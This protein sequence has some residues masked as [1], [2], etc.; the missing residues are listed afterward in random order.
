MN[1]LRLKELGIKNLLSHKDTNIVFEDVDNFILIHGRD[2]DKMTYA[3]AGKSGIENAITF[4]LFGKVFRG[5][6]SGSINNE[7]LISNWAKETKEPLEINL[8]MESDSGTIESKRQLVYGVPTGTN[9][10][11]LVNGSSPREFIT[12]QAPAKYLTE[13]ILQMDYKTFSKMHSFRTGNQVQF[14]SLRGM[15]Q[16]DIL[17]K[18]VSKVNFSDMSKLISEDMVIV[19]TKIEAYQRELESLQGQ[20]DTLKKHKANYVSAQKEKLEDRIKKAEKKKKECQKK[21]DQAVKELDRIDIGQDKI[22]LILNALKTMKK[23]MDVEA[24]SIKVKKKRVAAIRKL[25]KNDQCP[26]CYQ[27]LNRKSLERIVSE[28]V[29]DMRS[30]VQRIMRT[31]E[32][33]MI[34]KEKYD[35]LKTKL[36][37]LKQKER[38]LLNKKMKHQTKI[39]FY[40]R[41]IEHCKYDIDQLETT[42]PEYYE[43]KLSELKKKRTIV[44]RNLTRKNGEIERMK[45][46][47][48]SLK[49]KS[50]LKQFILQPLMPIFSNLMNKYFP[51]LW[52]SDIKGKV[53]ITPSNN[54]E[55]EIHEGKSADN[56]ES[57]SSGECRIIDIAALLS[58]IEFAN[59]LNR[60]TLGFMVIDEILESLDKVLVLKVVNLLKD[61]STRKGIQILFITN[62]SIIIESQEKYG[63]FDRELIFQKQNGV[64]RL[65]ENREDVVE[66]DEVR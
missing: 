66:F 15:D 9:T 63:L 50:P 29:D 51:I 3:G 17:E 55:F 23:E 14:F 60:T 34:R 57:A 59:I 65:I 12:P 41:E 46:C 62:N 56:Y 6:T 61:F 25:L 21:K 45:I 8:K 42:P 4:S 48:D 10:E 53:V 52:G 20:L 18:F 19:R 64:T 47:F 1:K 16:L 13:K 24:N 39:N 5:Q 40:T 38:E 36:E 58:F 27:D 32:L 7:K 49:K 22:D 44:K 35:S 33:Y 54:V 26:T 11:L 37:H 2:L 31:K 30:A 43:N 28:N